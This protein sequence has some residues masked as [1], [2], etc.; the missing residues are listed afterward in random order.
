MQGYIKP[1]KTK[2]RA[3]EKVPRSVSPEDWKWLLD[4]HFFNDDFLLCWLIISYDTCV[5]FICFPVI[6]ACHNGRHFLGSE[7]SKL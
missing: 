6:F 5:F 3:M 7:L 1:T 4:E 2:E